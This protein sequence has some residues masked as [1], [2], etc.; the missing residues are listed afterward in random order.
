MT[1]E[2]AY[3]YFYNKACIMHLTKV[4]VMANMAAMDALQK[5]IAQKVK[6]GCCPSC[7]GDVKKYNYCSHCGQ[8]LDWSD[9]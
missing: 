2:D 8:A 9:V 4:Q 1:F 5:Q 6:S 3:T 7:N